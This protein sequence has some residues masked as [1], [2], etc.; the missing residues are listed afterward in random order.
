MKRRN[1]PSPRDQQKTHPAL[2]PNSPGRVTRVKAYLP[3]CRGIAASCC[4]PD[5]N[6]AASATP[7]SSRQLMSSP[8]QLHTTPHDNSM[9]ATRLR[10]G[11]LYGSTASW[12]T[13][14]PIIALF[15]WLQW[16]SK[17]SYTAPLAALQKRKARMYFPV[18]LSWVFAT[19]SCNPDSESPPIVPIGVVLPL[20]TGAWIWRW[21]VSMH[22]PVVGQLVL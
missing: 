12:L 20:L 17:P 6:Q 18:Q 9:P 10:N 7:W 8:N 16:Q 14:W 1:M 19:T 4:D 3:C 11:T 15:S 21:S 22:A 2:Y 13:H 5:C